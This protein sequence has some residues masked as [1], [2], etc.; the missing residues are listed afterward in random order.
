MA[1]H[2]S[3]MNYPK[4]IDRFFFNLDAGNVPAF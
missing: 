3:K 4:P 1:D 2:F